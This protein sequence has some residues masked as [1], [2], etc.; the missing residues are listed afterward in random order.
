MSTILLFFM[1]N[2]QRK[3]HKN[4][5]YSFASMLISVPSDL[6]IGFFSNIFIPYFIFITKQRHKMHR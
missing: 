3:K 6:F 2:I 5:R 1:H 4:K